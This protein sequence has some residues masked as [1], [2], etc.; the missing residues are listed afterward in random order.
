MGYYRQIHKAP[1]SC[2]VK[3][4]SEIWVR[5]VPKN[6]QYIPSK[7]AVTLAV[8]YFCKEI[9]SWSYDEELEETALDDEVKAEV[10]ST[11]TFF[12]AG[13]NDEGTIFCPS[14]GQALDF[15]SLMEWQEEDEDDTL[16]YKFESRLLECC[17]ESATL[18]ELEYNYDQGFGYFCLEGIIDTSL[19][20]EQIAAFE[21]ILD[22]SLRVIYQAI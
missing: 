19:N 5:L 16:G 22:C 14:C 1:R 15:E 4:M 7:E 20:P 2:R 6:E 21:R 13:T 8:K 17:G 3:A 12:D 9:N 18:R 10:F 11:L